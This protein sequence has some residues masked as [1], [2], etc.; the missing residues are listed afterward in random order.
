MG[1]ISGNDL[2]QMELNLL[3]AESELTDCESSRKSCMFQLRTLLDLGENTNIIPLTPSA[4]LRQTSAMRTL[5]RKHS[6]A[7]NSRQASDGAS[8]RRI[9][10]WRRRRAT[11]AR[12]RFSP[13]SVILAL[14]DAFG[15][16][17][18]SLKDNRVVEIGFEIP[19]LDWGR[20]RGKVKVAESNRKVMESRLRQERADFSQNLFILVERYRN[21]MRQL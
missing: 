13:R 8:W 15:G 7:T 10:K 19:I 2:L 17:Y 20:R 3:N 14:T 5:C 9:M 16:A 1:R 4:L 12:Y 18:S 6:N 11:C 21:Q